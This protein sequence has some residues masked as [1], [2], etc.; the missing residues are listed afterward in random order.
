MT[1]LLTRLRA[2]PVPSLIAAVAIVLAIVFGVLAL[3]LN[4]S[5]G[6]NTTGD[7]T[8]T[9][10]GYSIHVPDGWTAKT[11]DRT[12]TVTSADGRTLISFGIGRTG[13]LPVAGTLF[14]QQVG[15][16][17]HQVQVFA[18]EAKQIGG[19]PAL[20]YGG[21]GVND[22]NAGIR[23]LAI[24]VTN[25]PTNYGI[26]VFTAADSDPAKVLPQADAIV[27]SFRKLPPT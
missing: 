25:N 11:Q 8:N 4:S 18:P 27:D 19:L 24:S 16:K 21:A 1:T 22:K 17:Y 9:A 26:A 10:G 20:V 7:V 6:T 12:T 13:P 3:V 23:F 2:R 14:F 15:G 5:S